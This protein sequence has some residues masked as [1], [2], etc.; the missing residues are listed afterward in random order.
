[1]VVS[2]DQELWMALGLVT[3][4]GLHTEDDR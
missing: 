4:V 1:M 3:L 2:N